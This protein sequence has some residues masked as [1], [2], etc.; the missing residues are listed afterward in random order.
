[1]RLFRCY[2]C[3]FS[4]LSNRSCYLCEIQKQP[5][6]V[7][8]ENVLKN[9]T[10]FTGEHLCQRLL[11]NKVAGLGPATL[12]KKKTLTQMFSCEFCEIFKS[13]FFYRTPSVAASGNNDVDNN[14]VMKLSEAMPGPRKH[15]RWRALQLTLLQSSPS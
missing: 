12:L 15:L 3:W 14:W 10:K 4:W 7:F 1:M 9:F 2:Y 8:W 11:F 13:I 5:T 6:K